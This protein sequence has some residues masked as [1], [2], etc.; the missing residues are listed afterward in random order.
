MEATRKIEEFNQTEQVLL[1][2]K[3]SE[4]EGKKVKYQSVLDEILMNTPIK[5]MTLQ[6][7]RDFRQDREA[8]QAGI[9][10]PNEKV[11]KTEEVIEKGFNAMVA[12]C[13]YE[14]ARKGINELSD[15]S[16]VEP[17]LT[18]WEILDNKKPE[19]RQIRDRLAEKYGVMGADSLPIKDLKDDD[20]LS[21]LTAT[22][23]FQIA[24]GEMP[25]GKLGQTLMNVLKQKSADFLQKFIVFLEKIDDETENDEARNEIHHYKAIAQAERIKKV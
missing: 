3:S 15:I 24:S 23:E 1:N 19:Y 21:Y 16:G 25:I 5:L 11:R 20:C 12:N 9:Y 7:Q 8:I 10:E 2:K 17:S 14:E 13:D 4:Q 18:I 6:Q 22:I